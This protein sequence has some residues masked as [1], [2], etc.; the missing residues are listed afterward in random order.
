MRVSD[1][2]T[3][4]TADFGGTRDPYPT[5]STKGQIP[6]SKEEIEHTFLDITQKFGFQRDLTLGRSR[7][8]QNQALFT[9]H[10]DYIGGQNANDRK[11][12]FAAQPDPDDAAG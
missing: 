10:A 5:W 6:L 11:W 1:S 8:S 7:M 2:S 4:T 12:Y 3:P 9:L